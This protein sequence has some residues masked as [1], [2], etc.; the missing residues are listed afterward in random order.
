MSASDSVW[1]VTT[2]R[3][4]DLTKSVAPTEIYVHEVLDIRNKAANGLMP[5]LNV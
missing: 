5:S 2:Q 4:E 1:T 3:N